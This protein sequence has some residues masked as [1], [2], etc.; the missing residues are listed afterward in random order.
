MLFHWVFYFYFYF[1]LWS[2]YQNII[3]NFNVITLLLLLCTALLLLPPF[4]FWLASF[5]WVN[6]ESNDVLTYW[7]HREFTRMWTETTCLRFAVFSLPQ[8]LRGK[9][10]PFQHFYM[11]E[12]GQTRSCV[13][14]L[15]GTWNNL[16]LAKQKCACKINCK[17]GSTMVDKAHHHK[18]L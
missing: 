2:K 7:N 14:F 8:T 11:M 13:L 4:F 12:G 15:S 9:T 3:R 6:S 5:N 18:W 10:L 16:D 17:M 1:L